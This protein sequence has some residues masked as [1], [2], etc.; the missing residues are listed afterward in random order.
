MGSV[1]DVGLMGAETRPQEEVLVHARDFINQ[2]YQ[3]LKK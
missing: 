3:S 2:Y 1:M